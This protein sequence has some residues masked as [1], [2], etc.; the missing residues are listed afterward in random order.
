[1]QVLNTFLD[2]EMQ[3]VNQI[4]ERVTSILAKGI[5]TQFIDGIQVLIAK[6]DTW[7]RMHYFPLC[8]A[9]AEKW[10]RTDNQQ[11]VIMNNFQFVVAMHL[12]DAIKVTT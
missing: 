4:C 1:M 12:E 8:T 7:Q 3:E 10:L 6:R 2:R 9:S 5:Q 11:S